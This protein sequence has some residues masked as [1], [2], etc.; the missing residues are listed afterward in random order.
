MTEPTW[1]IALIEPNRDFEA[2]CVFIRHG[3]RS[4]LLTRRKLR[5]GHDIPGWRKLPKFVSWPLI[6]GYIFLDL[7]PGDRWPS[8][9]HVR[10]Y[11]GMVN[12]GKTRMPNDVLAEW[13]QRCKAGEFD[14]QPATIANAIRNRFHHATDPDARRA[15]LEA[16]FAQL[17]NG[18]YAISA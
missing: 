3:F 14:D 10:G 7:R 8:A 6:P 18:Q 12:D 11:C 4:V 16:R 1:A 9:I 17:I 15:L 5:K 2:H 13:Q